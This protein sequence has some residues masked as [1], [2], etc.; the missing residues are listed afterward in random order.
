MLNKYAINA[1]FL[2]LGNRVMYNINTSKR[3]ITL[4]SANIK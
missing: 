4:N 3:F 1:I 2:T